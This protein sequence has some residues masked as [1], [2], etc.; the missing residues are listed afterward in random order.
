MKHVWLVLTLVLLPAFA[1]AQDGL[2]RI[3]YEALFRL[4]ADQVIVIDQG[5]LPPIRKLYMPGD[6]VLEERGPPDNRRYSGTD[7]S[8]GGAVWCMAMILIEY[9]EMDVKCP[10]ITTDAQSAQLD[11]GLQRVLKF[12]ADNTYPPVSYE[13]LAKTV[14]KQIAIERLKGVPNRTT[15]CEEETF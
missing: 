14:Q 15:Y 3:D 5:N 2:P 7:M 6:V 11:K 9:R 12:Y 4:H 8:G 1:L 13:A 10:N